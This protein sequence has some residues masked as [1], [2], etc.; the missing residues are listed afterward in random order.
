MTPLSDHDG[1]RTFRALYRGR[2][3]GLR[4]AMMKITNA[5]P[6]YLIFCSACP[7]FAQEYHDAEESPPIEHLVPLAEYVSR[8]D[9]A[10]ITHYVFQRCAG[11]AA[12]LQ[13]YAG[14]TLTQKELAAT[15]AMGN[16]TMIAAIYFELASLAQKRA[17]SLEDVTT[18]FLQPIARASANQIDSFGQYYSGR[19]QQSYLTH[20]TAFAEDALVSGDLAV[21]QWRLPVAA[22]VAKSLGE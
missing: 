12:G 7:A 4:L 9:D 10:Q 17:Q 11:L 15:E 16:V 14:K 3:S 22:S 1:E 20:G 19:M 8:P 6:A 13:Y 21:C 2:L 18:E 5:L